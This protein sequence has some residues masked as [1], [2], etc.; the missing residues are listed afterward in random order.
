MGIVPWGL[1]SLSFLFARPPQIGGPIKG[2]ASRSWLSFLVS[3]LETTRYNRRYLDVAILR[4][5]GYTHWA[6]RITL[7]GC[8]L[9]TTASFCFG[10]MARQGRTVPKITK[11]QAQKKRKNRVNV[12]LD[13]TY[14][15]GVQAIVGLSLKVGQE[16][17]DEAIADLKHADAF[18]IAHNRSLHF[19]SFRARSCFEVEKYLRGKRTDPDIVAEVRSCLLKAGLLDDV[20]FARYW[21]KNRETFRPRGSWGLRYELQQKGIAADVIS[22]AL[23]GLDFEDSAYRAAVR[24]AR[25][26]AHLDRRVFQRRIGDFLKRRGFSYSIIRQMVDRLWDEF[27]AVCGDGNLDHWTSGEPEDDIDVRKGQ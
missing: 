10:T 25:R 14:S 3:T 9:L 22:E 1:S 26:L 20:A 4:R 2:G 27:G 17:S 23:E 21:V 13:G 8:G 11:L 18:E 24:R 19:L 16:L 12:Y 5:N 7:G 6:H 15:F